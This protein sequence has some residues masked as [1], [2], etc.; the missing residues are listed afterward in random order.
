MN[1]VS[2]GMRDRMKLYDKVKKEFLESHRICETVECKNPSTQV[3][4]RAGRIGALLYEDSLFMAVCMSCHSKIE[5]KRQWARDMG[6]SL[7]RL[8]KTVH[9]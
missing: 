1:K 9:E 8:S 4:H 3:H 2:K 6:Y 7:D 5:E